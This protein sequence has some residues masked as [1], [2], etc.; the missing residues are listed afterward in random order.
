[1]SFHSETM[2]LQNTPK[3]FSWSQIPTKLFDDDRYLLAAWTIL[4]SNILL[5]QKDL[6]ILTKNNFVS[7]TNIDDCWSGKRLGRGSHVWAGS[8]VCIRFMD[9][10]IFP[11][12]PMLGYFKEKRYLYFLWNRTSERLVGR[13]DK[14]SY[15]L[16]S[17]NN[18]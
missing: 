9:T 14:I 2:L 12:F 6:F 18:Y 3:G 17:C 16:S 8:K 4:L 7:V 1:M 13:L 10:L 5:A 15:V 11:N